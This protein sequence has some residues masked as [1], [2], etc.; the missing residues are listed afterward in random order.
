MRR[1]MRR[2]VCR[3]VRADLLNYMRRPYL[4]LDVRIYLRRDVLRADMRTHLRQHLR[5]YV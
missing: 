2:H 4:H 5:I 3:D 1:N